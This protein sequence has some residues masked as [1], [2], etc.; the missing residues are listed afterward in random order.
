MKL[1]MRFD[2]H[3]ACQAIVREQLS[4]LGIDF[5]IHGMTE[6]EILQPLG[7]DEQRVL[8]LSLQ[9]YGIEF[10]DDPNYILVQKVRDLIIEMINNTES[11]ARFS[12]YLTKKLNHSYGHIAKVFSEFTFSSIENFVILQKIDKAKQLIAERQLTLTEI[13]WR[14]HYSSVQHLSTQFKK[15]TGI[16]PSAFQRIV[17][18]RRMRNNSPMEIKSMRS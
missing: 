7:L 17:Q 18:A 16:T 3:A 1:Q 14:L 15:T 5:Q 13:A 11:P 6:L 8:R 12:D 9:P 2:S 10:I 4:R